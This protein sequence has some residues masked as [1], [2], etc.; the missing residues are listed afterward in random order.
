MYSNG[1]KLQI[2]EAFNRLGAM[3]KNVIYY[4]IKGI[5]VNKNQNKAN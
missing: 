5:Y 1:C 3:Y 4:V 2:P